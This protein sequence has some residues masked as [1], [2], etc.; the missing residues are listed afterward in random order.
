MKTT[1]K[2]E[3]ASG[4]YD[5]VLMPK[6]TMRQIE[7]LCLA[8]AE[9]LSPEEIKAIREETHTSQAVFARH[10]NVTVSNISQWE[11]GEKCPVVPRSSC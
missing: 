7:E 5:A 1:Y 2:D 11:C 4:I 10:L 9:P 8:P 6:S 3:M